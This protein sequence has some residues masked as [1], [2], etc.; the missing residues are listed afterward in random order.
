MDQIV[1][2]LHKPRDVRNIGA[3]VRAMKNMGFGRLRLVAPAPFDPADLLGIAH[4]SEDVVGAIERYE[5]LPAALADARYVVGTS[6]RP[7]PGRPMRGDLRPLAAELVA[8]AAAAGPVAVLFGPEDNGLD[9]AALDRC[10][11]VLSLPADPAYP[12]LNL[13]QAA[14]LVLYELRVAAEGPAVA[15]APRTPATAGEHER[16]AEALAGAVGAVGFV[17]SG[18]GAATL[19]R[20][21]TL[22]ARAEPDSA[23]LAL[24][25]ALLREVAQA[26]GRRG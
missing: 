14:L 6:E 7:H 16:F 13:A 4:R 9:A 25:T 8:R 15:V 22:V 17:K 19:R 3:V 18:D 10:D 2:V 26:M 23:E 1:I 11:A 20:L 5:E 21:R 12:S 24:L